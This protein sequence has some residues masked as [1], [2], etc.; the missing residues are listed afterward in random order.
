MSETKAKQA[1]LR[2]EIIE[3]GF[4]PNLF[5]DYISQK[6]ENGSEIDAWTKEELQR[7]VAEFI[8]DQ[9]QKNVNSPR[10]KS[11]D[12]AAKSARYQTRKT[13]K[14]ETSDDEDEPQPQ[15]QPIRRSTTEA[16]R[17]SRS[18]HLTKADALTSTSHL[19]QHKDEVIKAFLTK[20]AHDAA[21]EQKELVV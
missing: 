18:T 21:V 16:E 1:F 11:L 8:A 20:A 12:E 17:A 9:R 15:K 10:K 2:R 7:L 5:V 3:Q 4:D 13:I 14:Y 19:E 6:K